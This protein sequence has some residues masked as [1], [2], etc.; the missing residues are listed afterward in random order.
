[1]RKTKYV[2][3][4]F[5][6]YDRTGIQDYLEKQAQNGWMLEK[7]GGFGWKFRR[8]EPKKIHFAVTFF[9][10]ASMFDPGPSEKELTFREFCAH[11]GWDLAAASAQMQIFCNDR[12]NPVPVE[13]DPMIELENLHATAR[14]VYLPTYF[15]M[16]L[17]GIMQMMNLI[18]SWKYTP[19]DVLSGHIYY[20][21]A[22]CF[23]VLI[24]MCAAELTG[25]F[26]WRS[27]AKKAAE[28]GLFVATSGSRTLQ[29]V[30]VCILTAALILLLFSFAEPKMAVMFAALIALIFAISAVSVGAT[31]LM[32]R[33]NLSATANR[34]ATFALILFLS[35]AVAGAGTMGIIRAMDE[36]WPRDKE[37]V[38]YEHNGITYELYKE[39]LPLMVEDLLEVDYDGYDC[40]WSKRQQTLLLGYSAA[41]QLP[42]L[43]R[44]D[45]PSLQYRIVDVKAG[46]LYDFCLNTMLASNQD[47]WS[48]DIY[49]NITTDEYWQ[50]DPTPW[51]AD[52][53]YQEYN[54]D[55]AHSTY[56]LCYGDQIIE[57][58]PDWELSEEQKAIVGRK[59]G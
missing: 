28:D 30:L 31:A 34:I 55:N 15:M 25:Y 16:L 53:A 41:Y 35:F 39:N 38:I 11:S 59:F 27:K 50:T 26:R 19:L 45:A 12:E 29:L 3:P 51:G 20:F 56:L 9:P 33:M 4:A 22:L 7:M 44:M 13:T 52:A 14:K 54:G 46:F 23:F 5:S 1:M 17:L 24:T 18:S 8:I 10:R 47:A 48:E 36:W 43:D 2:F 57:L 37:V 32:K 40:H 42:R 6:F 58:E 49:G 21:N